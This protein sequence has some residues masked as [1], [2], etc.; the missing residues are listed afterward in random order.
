MAYAYGRAEEGLFWKALINWQGSIS[1]LALA[2][3]SNT[4]SLLKSGY[5]RIVASVKCFLRPVTFQGILFVHM[6]EKSVQ[7]RA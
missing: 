7:V 3:V 2:F 6:N 4:K 1:C 5:A